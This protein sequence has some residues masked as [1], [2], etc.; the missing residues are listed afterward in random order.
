MMLG[1]LW[2]VVFVFSTTLHEAAHAWS[3]LKLGD[4][5]A[6]RSGQV[7]LD[8]TPHIRREPIGMVLIPI[9][10]YAFSGW[11]IGWASAPYNPLWAIHHP[12]KSAL[13]SLAG[14]AANLLLVILAG[15]GIRAG[16]AF[17]FLAAPDL[18]NFTH[19]TEALTPGGT[20]F[21]TLLSIVFSLNLLLCVFNLLPLPPLDG[22]GALLVFLK[23]SA[24]AKFLETMSSPG[25]AF[26]GLFV[27]WRVFGTIYPPIHLFIVNLLY[28]GL[29]YG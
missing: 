26:F 6:Y 18:I 11:M 8:P 22:S 27:A 7:T 10:S 17:H 3:A 29:G 14:P 19:V 21:A 2:Y 4:D 24:A 15:I 5:T 28:P 9:L 20:A 23:P 12:R 13:M 25:F 16:M 1:I